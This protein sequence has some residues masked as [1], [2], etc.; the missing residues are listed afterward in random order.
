VWPDFKVKYI[1]SGRIHYIF[2]EMLVGSSVEQTIAASGFLLSRCN[3]R[4]KYFT[5]IDE[6][7][8][9]QPE[10]FYD[11]R[12]V[13]LNIARREGLNENQFDACVQDGTALQALSARVDTN[14]TRNHINATPSFV[15]NGVPLEPGY[16]P[17][18]EL[19]AAIARAAATK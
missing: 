1:D 4:D 15:V 19:D 8:K 13:L 10:L 18:A 9:S 3:G 5:I 14:A 17:L 7:F 6:I 16:R 12:T 2:R 11:P